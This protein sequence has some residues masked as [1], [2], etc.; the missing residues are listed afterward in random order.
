M[1]IAVVARDGR[2]FAGNARQVGASLRLSRWLRCQDRI[3]VS[4]VVEERARR[5]FA[6]LPRPCAGGGASGRRHQRR[7]DAGIPRGAQATSVP[8]LKPSRFSRCLRVPGVPRQFGQ[9]A[10]IGPVDRC[11]YEALAIAAQAAI[12]SQRE[13]ADRKAFAGWNC[14]CV[15][16]D[17]RR[18]LVRHAAEE[19]AR[20]TMIARWRAAPASIRLGCLR[21]SLWSLLPPYR[22]C[23]TSKDHGSPPCS[24]G[25]FGRS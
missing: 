8:G 1:A 16:A 23:P 3:R 6:A 14:R 17:V 18:H 4:N 20:Y 15:V 10:P 5:R 2:D 12:T 21:A 22:V 7:G 25:D 9:G 19:Y 13:G 24:G 11:C